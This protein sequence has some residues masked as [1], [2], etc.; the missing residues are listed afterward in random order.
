MKGERELAK[1]FYANHG[2]TGRTGVSKILHSKKH[3][4][5]HKAAGYYKN[6]KGA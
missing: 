3:Y 6:R 1:E 4:Q 2:K 5:K